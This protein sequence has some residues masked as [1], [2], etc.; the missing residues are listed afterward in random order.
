MKLLMSIL[1]T[2]LFA[3]GVSHAASPTRPSPEV[4]ATYQDIQNTLGI[5]PTF[6]RNYPE[7]GISAAW[8]EF[9]RIELDKQTF[10]SGKTK[11]LIGLSVAAQIPCKFCVYFHTESARANGATDAEIKEAIAMSA[12][13]RHWSTF[14]NGSQYS[15][16]EFQKEV[17]TIMVFL[18]NQRSQPV[19]AQ[20]KSGPQDQPVIDA[21]SAYQDIERTL[22]SVPNYFKLFPEDSIS[23]AWKM[24]KTIQLNPNTAIPS[25]EKELIS[26][27]VSA[28]VPC[29]YCTYFHTEAAKLNGAST[30]EIRETIAMAS[31][32]RFWSTVIN[33][34]QVD[35]QKFKKEVGQIIRFVKSQ[36]KRVGMK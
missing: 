27:A 20:V 17:N 34:T 4:Q 28:Q 6:M 26:L 25:K 1:L 10:L 33:G 11:E 35:E 29:N 31:L 18:K 12:A 13:T 36:N 21:K 24:M 2:T 5:V 19:A 7:A 9:K 23:G 32:T 30:E 22:G 16:A 15:D 8:E 14:L 3:L